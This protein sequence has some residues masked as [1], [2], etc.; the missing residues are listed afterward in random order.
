MQVIVFCVIML[1]KKQFKAKSSEMN[2]H[3]LCLGN[4]SKDF[5]V[6][7]NKRNRIEC[8]YIHLFLFIMILLILVVLQT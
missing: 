3:Q 6:D 7:N 8:I 4:I 5:A 2:A 1:K